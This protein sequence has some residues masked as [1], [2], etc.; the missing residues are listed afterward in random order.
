MWNQR[1]L[2]CKLSQ[3]NS[4]QVQ[5]L[6]FN[7]HSG[8]AKPITVCHERWNVTEVTVDKYTFE[9]LESFFFP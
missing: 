8:D 1:N 9:V 3:V 6:Y 5:S 4:T 2:G 7:V